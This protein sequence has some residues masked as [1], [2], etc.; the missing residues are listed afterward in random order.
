M[1]AACGYVKRA[2]VSLGDRSH[3]P[4]SMLLRKI[5]FNSCP[6]SGSPFV[7]AVKCRTH[8]ANGRFRTLREH[9]HDYSENPLRAAGWG[10]TRRPWRTRMS[11][12]KTANDIAFNRLKKLV[13]DWQIA[14]P[15]NEAENRPSPCVIT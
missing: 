14:N 2:A 13:G 15:R 12:E 1:R 5:L 3:R 11:P 10:G 9:V 8:G 7:M 4:L 6:R